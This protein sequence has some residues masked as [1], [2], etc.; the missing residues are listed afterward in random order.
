LIPAVYRNG[1]YE[2]RLEVAEAR[3]LQLAFELQRALGMI[4][5]MANAMNPDKQMPS[6][7]ETPRA[8]GR[9]H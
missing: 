4:E 1:R 9:G 5:H 3:I 2:H 8:F 6:L 7:P